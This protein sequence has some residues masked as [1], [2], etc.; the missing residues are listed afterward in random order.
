[1]FKNYSET[2]FTKDTIGID[3][4]DVLKY[5]KRTIEDYN[6]GQRIQVKMEI[7][8]IDETFQ[9]PFFKI[10]WRPTDEVLYDED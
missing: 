7:T 3:D 5:R 10:K 6:L 8:R 9:L 4:Y 1:M 2:A